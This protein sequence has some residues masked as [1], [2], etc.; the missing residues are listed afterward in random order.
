MYH[1]CTNMSVKATL[2]K[3]PNKEGMCPLT[4]RVTK[5]RKSTFIYLGYHIK[6]EDWNGQEV[7]RSHPNSKRLN[8]LI[9]HRKAELLETVIE[10]ETAKPD[11]STTSIR[12]KLDQKT[13]T[14]FVQQAHIYLDNLKKSGRYNQYTADKSRLKRFCAFIA[15][16]LTLQEVTVAVLD[17]FKTSLKP[18]GLS[19]RTI[20]N[21]LAA[22][23]CVFGMAIRH[24][25][26]DKKYSPFGEVKIKFPESNK[27]GLNAEEI[28]RLETVKL[29]NPLHN[30]ARNLWLFS[31]YFAG[32]R[33]S[34]VLRLKWTDIQNDRLYYSMGKNTKAGSLKI[35]H[36][37]LAILDQYDRKQVFI[38]PE[39]QHKD[40]S[41][42][43]IADRTIA[44]ATS[45]LDKVL[46]LHIAPAAK[47]EKKVTMHIARHTFGDISG[48][49]IPIQMLQ[50]LYRHS[51]VM[52][53]IGYQRNFINQDTDDALLNVVNSLT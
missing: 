29:E 43:F 15:P 45:R 24:E 49:K 19:E 30:H 40:L 20:V 32:M 53:T 41:D 33:I 31:F 47:I 26:I 5:D 7:K 16:T 22:I 36:K 50:K 10:M 51:S 34:D 18:L 39:L 27:I 4:L 35:H 6:P 14:T 37:A 3:K 48:D 28:H 21:H 46:R 8:N 44:F 25:V 9:A 23:R 42:K 1:S 13:N 2:R 11:V 52:T 12:A 38:F 17:R